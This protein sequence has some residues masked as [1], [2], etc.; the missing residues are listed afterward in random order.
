MNPLWMASVSMVALLAIEL[1]SAPAAEMLYPVLDPWRGRAA[2]SV[3]SYNGFVTELLGLLALTMG[4]LDLADRDLGE[5]IE[6]AER[7]GTRVSLVRSR[8]GR[9]RALAA[10]GL[11]DAALAEAEAVES[12]ARVLGTTAVADAARA[13]ATRCTAD[14]RS[15]R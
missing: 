6:Q 14:E 15:T 11:L 4:D 5:A 10:R 1:D 3:V 7:L 12:E 2:T 9:A 8:F 13:L